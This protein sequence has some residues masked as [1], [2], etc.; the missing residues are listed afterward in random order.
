MRSAAR[1]EVL[2]SCSPSHRLHETGA[3]LM[4][5][6]ANRLLQLV[7]AAYDNYIVRLS[8]SLLGVN[9]VIRSHLSSVS[10]EVRSCSSLTS[11]P[12]E[13]KLNWYLCWLDLCMQV[14]NVFPVLLLASSSYPCAALLSSRL[15][16]RLLS[17]Q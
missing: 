7:Q 17:L 16:T 14:V 8:Q 2:F 5:T 1:K 9:H 4:R 6:S 11:K 15:T 13:L 3:L 10:S 12:L